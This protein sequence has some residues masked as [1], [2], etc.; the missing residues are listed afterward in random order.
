[1]DGIALRY[2]NLFVTVGPLMECRDTNGDYG[3]N[4]AVTIG[5]FRELSIERVKLLCA[6]ASAFRLRKQ[7]FINGS[8]DNF[9]TNSW[10]A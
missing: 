2:L 4:M 9:H 1:M 7:Y 10:N 3:I 6:M 5:S 8:V